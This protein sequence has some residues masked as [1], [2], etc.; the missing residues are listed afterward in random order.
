VTGI[1]NTVEYS[2]RIRARQYA[3]GRDYSIILH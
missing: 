2:D 3:F 1:G